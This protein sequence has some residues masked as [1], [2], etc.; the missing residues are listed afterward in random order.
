LSDSF[1]DL[2]IGGNLKIVLYAIGFCEI[3]L[4]SGIETD[5]N[6]RCHGFYFLLSG[7]LEGIAS[8]ET[9]PPTM[10][11]KSTKNLANVIYLANFASWKKK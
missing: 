2:S 6:N 9:L 8:R 7:C 11:K 4:I 5:E 10:R 1:P 3:M